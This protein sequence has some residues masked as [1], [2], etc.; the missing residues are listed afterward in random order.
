V[1]GDDRT[2]SAVAPPTI[3]GIKRRMI[4]VVTHGNATYPDVM[5][6][7]GPNSTQSSSD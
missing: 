4:A 2:T 3:T 1:D 7:N 6:P 5:V